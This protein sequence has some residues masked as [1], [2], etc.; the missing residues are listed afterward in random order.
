MP[1]YSIGTSVVDVFLNVVPP[2]ERIRVTAQIAGVVKAIRARSVAPCKIFP[3]IELLRMS[4]VGARP[5]AIGNSHSHHA[6]RDLQLAQPV[7]L[8]YGVAFLY[9][10]E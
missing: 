4:D 9:E 8:A 10:L 7:C 1:R 5:V 6:A 3:D 2:I